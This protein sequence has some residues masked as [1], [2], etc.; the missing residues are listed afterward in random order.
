MGKKKKKKKKKR[1]VDQEAEDPV[2]NTED[3]L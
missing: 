1:P 3:N 2:Q